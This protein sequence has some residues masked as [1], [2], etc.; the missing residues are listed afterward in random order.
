ML[1][2]SVYPVAFNT[3][4]PLFISHLSICLFCVAQ[5]AA[6]ACFTSTTD[7]LLQ[8]HVARYAINKHVLLQGLAEAGINPTQISPADGAFYLYAYMSR[9]YKLTII[10]HKSL[11]RARHPALKN[12]TPAVFPVP[13]GTLTLATTAAAISRIRYVHS[14]SH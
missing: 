5:I 2:L 12:I 10:Y 7:A 13:T 3:L 11:S 8:T 14:Q 6:E 9:P 1:C 4:L